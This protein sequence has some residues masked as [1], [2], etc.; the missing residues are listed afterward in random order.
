MLN[1]SF[2][3]ENLHW[4]FALVTPIAVSLLGI[5]IAQS[6]STTSHRGAK[7]LNDCLAKHQLVYFSFYFS[8]LK[9]ANLIAR[10]QAF[11]ELVFFLA[12]VSMLGYAVS[13]WVV[14]GQDERIR[15]LH[16]CTRYCTG[17]ISL[18]LW[19]NAYFVVLILATVLLVG[20]LL[21]VFNPILSGSQAP[22]RS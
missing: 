17:S 21:I 11:E 13:V 22:T 4:F 15:K 10:S 5:V 8:L 19:F 14:G 16:Q 6:R 7:A 9:G 18:R 3:T 2:E 20:A 1:L 12:I